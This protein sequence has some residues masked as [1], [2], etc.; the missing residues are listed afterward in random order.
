[1]GKAFIICG[2]PAAGKSTY[3]STLAKSLKAVLIDID[4]CTE[5][6]VQTSL[7]S[8]GR[9]PD[10][11]DS[12][13]FKS[14]F[15]EPVYQTLFN[16]ARENLTWIDT[17]IVGPFTKEL[18]D[19][20]WPKTLKE[21]LQSEIEVHYITCDINERKKRMENRNN[22]RD[23]PKLKDWDNHIK[24]FADENPPVFEHVFV[25]TSCNQL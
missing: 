15:R 18:R 5:Q 2:S 12:P 10:D 6:L 1:M 23:I 7:M 16:I 9:N 13:Y 22:P 25:N 11:R 21:I 17:V 4:T 19:I 3:G 20:N 14:T 24:Y 8:N